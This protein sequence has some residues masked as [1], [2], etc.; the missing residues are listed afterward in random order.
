MHEGSKDFKSITLRFVPCHEEHIDQLDKCTPYADFKEYIDE[1]ISAL[2]L[3]YET[4]VNLNEAENPISKRH[5]L[6]LLNPN[7]EHKVTLASSKFILE[8][9]ILGFITKRRSETEFLKFESQKMNQ[10][11]PITLRADNAQ[12]IFPGDD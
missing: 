5:N 9:D 11:W 4:K 1:T 8:E 10:A 2:V 3:T 6:F 7:E 12:E